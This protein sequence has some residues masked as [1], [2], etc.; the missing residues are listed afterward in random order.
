MAF[1]LK[2]R[3]DIGKSTGAGVMQLFTGEQSLILKGTRMVRI[4]CSLK[5]NQV[6]LHLLHTTLPDNTKSTAHF[7][8]IRL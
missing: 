3:W 7:N 2:A 1:C 8:T 6:S 5:H 4:D